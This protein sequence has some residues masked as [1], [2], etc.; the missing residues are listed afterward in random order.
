MPLSVEN[1]GHSKEHKKSFLMELRYFDIFQRIM[2]NK[3][4][5]VKYQ[6]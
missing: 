5:I 2:Q 1:G 3:L 4:A 6:S